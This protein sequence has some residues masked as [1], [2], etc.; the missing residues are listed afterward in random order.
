MNEAPP[1]SSLSTSIIPEVPA[2]TLRD[3]EAT[4]FPKAEKE[5]AAIASGTL[6][7]KSNSMNTIGRDDSRDHVGQAAICMIWMVFGFS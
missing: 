4:D 7:E 3:G 2:P 5:A 1:P 6:E